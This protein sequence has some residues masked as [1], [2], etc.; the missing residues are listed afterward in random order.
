MLER[1]NT[2]PLTHAADNI[3][4]KLGGRQTRRIVDG[5]HCGNNDGRVRP[6]KKSYL[7]SEQSCQED[8]PWDQEKETTRNGENKRLCIIM[9]EPWLLSQVSAFGMAHDGKVVLGS[10]YADGILV[11]DIAE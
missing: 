6:M 9:M 1:E 8:L 2:I 7:K 4:Y 3:E 11:C 5:N 10:A